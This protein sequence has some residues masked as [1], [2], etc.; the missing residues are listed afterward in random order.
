MA[1]F[2]RFFIAPSV[3]VDYL[4]VNQTGY[5][6]T[7]DNDTTGLVLAVAGGDI[8]HLASTFKLSLGR[9]KGIF[10]PEDKSGVSPDGRRLRRSRSGSTQQIYV[11]YRTDLDS[12][13][14]QASVDFL[15]ST[16]NTFTIGDLTDEENAIVFGATFSRVT[17]NLFVTMG[18]KG[19]LAGDYAAH[20]V[21]AELRFSF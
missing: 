4:D 6:E 9:H 2:G 21:H 11:G 1:S 14:Y 15:A 20:K 12:T 17:D 3:T 13:P 8:Q 7:S 5:V 16:G 10:D 18:Y 19:E